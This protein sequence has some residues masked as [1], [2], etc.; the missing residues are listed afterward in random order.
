MIH[1][2][3]LNEFVMVHGLQ[4]LLHCQ[5]GVVIYLTEESKGKESIQNISGKKE[6][7]QKV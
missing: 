6:L 3:M 5:I 2:C 7:A 4:R 1:D